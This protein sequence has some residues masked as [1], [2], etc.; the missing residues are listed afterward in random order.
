MSESHTNSGD[1]LPLQ[2]GPAATSQTTITVVKADDMELRR[3]L[4]PPGEEIE[5]QQM[6]GSLT[7][8]CLEGKISVSAHDREQTLEKGQMIY[9]R[10]NE[11]HS[12][13]AIEQSAILITA[14]VPTTYTEPNQSPAQTDSAAANVQ[15]SKPASSKPP[16]PDIVDEASMESFPASD[17]PARS[18]ITRA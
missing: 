5:T 12:I 6:T 10:A 14:H 8:H 15:P 7:V 17:P 9:L 18:A 3:I 11:P 4:M 13:K 1:I 2:L 16:M